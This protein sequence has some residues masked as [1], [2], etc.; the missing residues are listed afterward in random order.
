MSLVPYDIQGFEI[1]VPDSS[2]YIPFT[3]RVKKHA[4]TA[5]AAAV[6]ALNTA[7][8]PVPA[9]I[10]PSSVSTTTIANTEEEAAAA[11]KKAEEEAARLAEEKK[12]TEEAAAAKN[13]N[14]KITS[15]E[16]AI[17]KDPN[18]TTLN[19]IIDNLGKIRQ[20]IVKRFPD[21]S[22]TRTVLINRIDN[23]REL[24]KAKKRKHR[25]GTRK[26]RKNLRKT[27]KNRK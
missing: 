9:P 22:E 23:L 18:N 12:A 10:V 27:R 11:K 26:H 8:T 17:A 15:K 5:N 4:A 20:N 19:D 1:G 25:G 14:D 13:F 24:A 2:G 7:N 3:G 16:N 6:A 21:E